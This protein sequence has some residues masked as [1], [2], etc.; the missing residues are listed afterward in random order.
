MEQSSKLNSK[1]VFFKIHRRDKT[2]ILAICDEFLFDKELRNEKIRMKI[3]KNFYCGQEIS[4]SD[5]LQLMRKYVNINVLGSVLEEGIH[6]N[7]I[8]KEAV[9]WLRTEDG[10]DIP[11]LLIF[12]I[13]PI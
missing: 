2:E 8:N 5:A 4:C 1:R 10:I 6:L 3:P 9:I 7:Q 11:H 12:S 13:P